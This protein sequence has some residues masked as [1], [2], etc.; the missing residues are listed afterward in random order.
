MSLLSSGVF[1]D[2]IQ[3][4]NQGVTSGDIDISKLLGSVQ[5]MLGNLGGSQSD[6][7]L[8]QMMNMATQMTSNMNLNPNDK[9]HY[10]PQYIEGEDKIITKYIK[11]DQNETFQ[12]TLSDGRPYILDVNRY[13]SIHHHKK[14]KM[15][16]AFCGDI[17]P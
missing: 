13:S 10:H 17:P 4:M 15:N 14:N 12:I 11:I 6:P 3:T 7:Q 2:M 16:T 1:T 9:Y 8:S 5:G